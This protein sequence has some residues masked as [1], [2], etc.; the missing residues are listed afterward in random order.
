MLFTF[1]L[2]KH[3]LGNNS[4]DKTDPSNIKVAFHQLSKIFPSVRE[5]DL[6]YAANWTVSLLQVTITLSLLL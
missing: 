2:L 4:D 1:V 6:L 5:K 3:K